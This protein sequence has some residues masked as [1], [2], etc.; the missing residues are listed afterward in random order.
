MDFKEIQEFTGIEAETPEQF[1]ELF[2]KSFVRKKQAWE[3]PD[4]KVEFQGKIMGKQLTTL[5]QLASDLGLDPNSEEFKALA[6]EKGKVKNEDFIKMLVDSV[7]KTKE[8]EIADLKSKQGATN[9]E[10][11]KL[12]EE[13][14]TK[15]RAKNT[16]L[17]TNWKK[18]AAELD[19]TK[20]TFHE[21]LKLQTIDINLSKE[22]EKVKIK[23]KP[24]EVELLG[25]NA[26]IKE[27]LRFDLDENNQFIVTDANGSRIP[28]KNKAA[29]F[30]D[31]H[32]AIQEVAN[33]L[34]LVEQNPHGGNPAPSG[35]GRTIVKNTPAPAGQP[36]K[37]S[38]IKLH[39]NAVKAAEGQ[40]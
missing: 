35:G 37:G 15:L 21:K 40:S 5:R 4:L 28:D 25:F 26:A 13:E 20:Q 33:S 12:K 3:D 14:I 31:P 2:Q 18:T 34:G 1:K 7:A 39:P 6:D 11:I 23:P 16:D 36:G 30:L 24:S 8:A 22:R 32:E 10:V 38:G 29:R 19:T 17:E 27:K 9:D